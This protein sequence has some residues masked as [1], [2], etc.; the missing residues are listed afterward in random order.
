MLAGNQGLIRK[1]K[2]VVKLHK[3]AYEAMLLLE[4]SMKGQM[5]ALH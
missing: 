3:Q 5:K 2:N 4:Y 1:N